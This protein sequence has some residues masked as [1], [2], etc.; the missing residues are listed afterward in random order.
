MMIKRLQLY[1]FGI[2]AGDNSFDFTLEK[3][4][5]LI[6][7][8]NGRGKTTFLEAIVLSLYGS[9]SAAYKE[10][11]Y[12]TYGQYLRSLVNRDSCN[13]Q[14]FVELT[15]IINDGTPIEYT[16]HREWD[17][18]SKR[19]SEKTSVEEN[20]VFNEFLT[21]NWSMFVENIVPSA[22]SSF[23]FFDGEKIAE[24][25]LDESNTQLRESI[26]SM[27]GLNILDVL[28][29]D[30]Q[31]TLRRRFRQ[32]TA[33]IS[34]DT[35]QALKH[36]QEELTK[37]VNNK[38]AEIQELQVKASSLQGE[39]DQLQNNYESHGGKVIE[40]RA[41]LIQEKA[42]IMA[43][44]EQIQAEQFNI[45]ASELPLQMV[46]D[47]IREIKLQAEDEHNEQV[48]CQLIERIDDLLQN[49]L[50]QERRGE[51]T[52]RSFVDFI[53]QKN[54]T[55]TSTSIYQVSEFALFQLNSLLDGTLDHAKQN[56]VD[57]LE[58]KN[59]LQKKLEEIESHLSLDIN[60]D[61]LSRIT[62]SIRERQEALVTSQVILNHAVQEFSVLRTSL[63]AK[64]TE[65]N[66]AVDSYLSEA[67]VA[68]VN[69]RMDKYTHMAL[70]ILDAYSIEV[71]RKKGNILAATITD[72][73]HKLA[74][75]R[76][77]IDCITVNPET[78]EIAYLDHGG[79]QLSSKMLSSGEK[80]L[81]VISVLWA[82]AICSKKKLPV[83]IDTP[84][85]R[86]DSVHRASVVRNYFPNA[87][88]QTMIL[89]TDSEIDR[90]Y[91]ELIKN[92]VGDEFT[93][94]YDED[95]RSTTILKGYFVL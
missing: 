85:S 72:C 17:S 83:I 15:F 81:M 20:G 23:Y 91:Y 21:N 90:K 48:M 67:S 62:V 76:R 35:I 1:N 3:P 78:L 33:F 87:S 58:H 54:D 69:A 38:E 40:Q 47:L 73:Y 34:R 49:Y 79:K 45:A 32:Q 12:K 43:S 89:S 63:T 66:E 92:S 28:K 55:S 53:K 24:L 11:S 86:L 7:G 93:L 9:N 70:R 22:L 44:L 30:L 16:V 57:I 31:K 4:V 80:Q 50:L 39:I 71:Q 68:D 37:V 51:E 36:Q 74:N 10:S 46:K 94:K 18:N 14:A 59:A 2:Y 6:G 84:L 61:E 64:A 60:E 56:A 29:N 25:A 8:M 41:A 82:L 88:D 52:C 13:Q 95:T 26:R 5:V 75:K 77:M 42:A 19:I 65:V 27:L